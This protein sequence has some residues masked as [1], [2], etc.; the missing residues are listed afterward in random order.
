MIVKLR[1]KYGAIHSAL[2]DRYLDKLRWNYITFNE[3][4]TDNKAVTA[5]VSKYM[6]HPV[7]YEFLNT[8]K[9]LTEERLKDVEQSL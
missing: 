1:G 9:D 8:K 6:G 2:Y 4:I 5:Y 3:P 7:A